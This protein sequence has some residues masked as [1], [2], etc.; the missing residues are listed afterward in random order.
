MVSEINGNLWIALNGCLAQSLRF[1]YDG[2]V[3]FQDR[4]K[5]RGE[6]HRQAKEETALKKAEYQ[7]M[8]ES[9]ALGALLAIVGG[10]LD[11]YTYLLR[12]HVFANAQTGNIVLLGLNLAS[13]QFLNA[14]YYLVPI[15][16][17][18][19]GVVA[20]EAVKQKF[21]DHPRIHWRQIIVAAEC[22]LLLVV[23]FVPH[24][25]L[26]VAVNVSVSFLC[27]MQVE[28]FRKFEGNAFAT[29]MC[30]GNLR[31]AMELLYRYAVTGDCREGAKCLRY[32][33]I[34]LFFILGA[35]LGA[36]FTGLFAERA[37]LFC[38]GALAAA[39]GLMFIRK[40]QA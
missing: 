18:A 28:S 34:I 15:G 12:G 2:I 7:Q 29:T 9:F 39:F 38:C 16:A 19:A 23:A 31:S 3:T 40:K 36:W 33:G 5:G 14:V 26:D 35:V 37:V 8:S 10:F 13:L 21:L 22:L 32:F 24:G 1:C 6:N 25:G 4:A 17:F 30:T 20:T 11:A 27:A